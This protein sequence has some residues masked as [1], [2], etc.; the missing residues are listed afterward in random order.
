MRLAILA[1][2]ISAIAAFAA[3]RV[4]LFGEFTS[5]Y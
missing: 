5:I 1:L 4:V 3:D 2:A